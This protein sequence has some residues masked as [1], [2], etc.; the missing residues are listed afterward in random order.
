MNKVDRSHLITVPF[1]KFW[2]LLVFVL[3]THDRGL[4]QLMLKN[5]AHSGI[6]WYRS[7]CRKQIVDSTN[8]LRLAK[9]MNRHLCFGH[10]FQVLYDR[11]VLKCEHIHC[12]NPHTKLCLIFGA[13]LLLWYDCTWPVH[14]DEFSF[15]CT[16]TEQMHLDLDGLVFD[17]TWSTLQLHQQEKKLAHFDTTC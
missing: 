13:Q 3:L 7:S 6:Y 5:S 17:C 10:H 4:G 8:Q 12:Q 11:F 14:F 9:F 1:Q 16:Q 2:C 15:N